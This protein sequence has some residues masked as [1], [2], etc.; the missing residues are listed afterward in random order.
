MKTENINRSFCKEERLCSTKSIDRLFASGVSFV[1]YPL[2]VVFYLE[3]E[4]D[5]GK[6]FAKILVSVSKKKFKRAVKRNRVKRLIKEAYRLNKSK[7]SEVL[8]Q[9]ERRMDI[10]FLYLKG[11]LPDYAEIEK[12]IQKAA[13]VL[14][15]KLKDKEDDGK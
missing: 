15:E 8:R 3:N 2:R 12:A 11:E 9:N 6:R 13:F 7:Y 1:A 4:P 5:E 10:A 14:N